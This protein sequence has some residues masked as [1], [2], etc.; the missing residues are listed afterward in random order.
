M[1]ETNNLAQKYPEVVER[2]TQLHED[3]VRQV[4]M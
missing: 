1:A 4:G 2:L 3:W